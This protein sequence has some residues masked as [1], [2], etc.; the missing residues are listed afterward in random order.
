MI[1]WKVLTV[2]KQ[3][4]D[5]VS[6]SLSLGS[7]E[8]VGV[9]VGETEEDYLVSFVVDEDGQG[10]VGL[11]LAK[12]SVISKVS[13]DSH[14]WGSDAGPSRLTIEGDSSA[15]VPAS[16][17]LEAAAGGVKNYETVVESDGSYQAPSSPLLNRAGIG[18]RAAASTASTT[19]VLRILFRPT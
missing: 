8:I 6:G 1:D 14:Y 17:P 9:I 19:D 4:K 5:D 2:A 15:V 18:A 16:S 13:L 12:A 3:L 11:R 10:P 7:E